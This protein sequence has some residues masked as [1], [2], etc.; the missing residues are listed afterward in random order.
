M[1][2]RLVGL[3]CAAV[4]DLR[5]RVD[6]DGHAHFVIGAVHILSELRFYGRGAHVAYLAGQPVRRNASQRTQKKHGPPYAYENR[7][8]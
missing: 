6:L 3:A 8:G 5:D 7:H 2:N 1:H 4:D